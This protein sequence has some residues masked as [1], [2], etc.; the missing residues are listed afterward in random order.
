MKRWLGLVILFLIASLGLFISVN[1]SALAID[2]FGNGACSGRASNTGVCQESANTTGNSIFNDAQAVINTLLVVV[3]II[4]VVMMIV[5]GLKLITS[6]GD[7]SSV[8]SGKNTIMYAIIGLVL[9]LLSFGIVNFV[10][11]EL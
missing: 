8:T 5:G 9:A 6:N 11:A 3:G 7:A 4:A 2:A 1:N 10:I